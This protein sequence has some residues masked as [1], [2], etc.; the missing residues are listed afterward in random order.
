MNSQQAGKPD[1]MT[2]EFT[3]LVSHD[4]DAAAAAAILDPKN[5]NDDQYHRFYG[6]TTGGAYTVTSTLGLRMRMDGMTVDDVGL[7]PSRLQLPALLAMIQAAGALRRRPAGARA[8]GKSG[9]AV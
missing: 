3:N 5:A 4:F 7:R 2:G 6:K 9:H 8:H 1:K